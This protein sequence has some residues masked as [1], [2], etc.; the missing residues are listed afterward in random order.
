MKI[1]A[2][3]HDY[4]LPS[5]STFSVLRLASIIKTR[6]AT[7]PRFDPTF[8]GSTPIVLA[9]LEVDVAVICAALPVFWPVL[10]E[11]GLGQILVTR[12]FKIDFEQRRLSARAGRMMQGARSSY[13]RGGREEDEDEEDGIELRRSESGLQQN[14]EQEQEQEQRQKNHYQ[15]PFVAQQVSPFGK[16]EFGVKFAIEDSLPPSGRPSSDRGFGKRS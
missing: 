10:C 5:A 12:E 6:A 7:Y 9:A 2:S 16:A 1:W 4:L 14:Q 8:Y 3:K 13:R 15:D 11:M